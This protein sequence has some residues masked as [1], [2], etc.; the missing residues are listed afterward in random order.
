MTTT[1]DSLEVLMTGENSFIRLSH[2]GGQTMSDRTSHWRVL[3]CPVG[4]GHVLFMEG[5]LTG[6]AVRIYSDNEAVARWIQSTIESLLHG[7][8]ADVNQPIT[9][10]SFSREGDPS[11]Q[12]TE[13]IQSDND[14]IR[15]VWNDVG[16]PF[17]LHAP[18]GTGGRPLGVLSTFFPARS[19]Q[20]SLNE[21]LASGSAWADKRGNN[22]S[23]SCVLA[24]SE[25]WL[26]P[27]TT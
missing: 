24:W 10:A 17:I 15:M 25:S 22:S 5:E 3:W 14:S 8:F 1:L 6:G 27:R 21:Q 9:Q 19:A 7:P 20:L 4:R 2:D 18:P 13:L 16:K 26:K 12:T 11:S 23:S